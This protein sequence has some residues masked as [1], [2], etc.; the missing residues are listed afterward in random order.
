MPGGAR[1]CQET[2]EGKAG[3]ADGSS[4]FSLGRVGMDLIFCHVAED[5]RFL[6]MG[7]TGYNERPKEIF[8]VYKVLPRKVLI[9]NVGYE[10]TRHAC[11]VKYSSGFYSFIWSVEQLYGVS[12]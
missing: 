3:Q 9:L 1:L 11:G 10:N 2:A 8:M 12:V 6:S 4:K 7:V 5:R